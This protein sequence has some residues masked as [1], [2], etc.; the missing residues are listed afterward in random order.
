MRARP[1]TTLDASGS[2]LSD[3]DLHCQLR[4]TPGTARAGPATTTTRRTGPASGS[5]GFVAPS[6]VVLVA[7][8]VGAGLVGASG[9]RGSRPGRPPRR[10]GR[11]AAR[12]RRSRPVEAEPA[13]PPDATGAPP[14]AQAD[15][16]RPSG[17]WWWRWP[18][19][20]G[21]LAAVLAGP[22]HRVRVHRR[23][24]ALRLR[25]RGDARPRPGPG[26]P[27]GSCWAPG[28]AVLAPSGFWFVAGVASLVLA[29][30]AAFLPRR[31]LVGA[32]VGLLAVPALMRAEPFGFTGASALC[33]WLAVL[34]VLVSGY[35]VASRRSRER[36]RTVAT[37]AVLVALIG[38]I[39]FALAVWISFH[40][41]SSGSKSAQSGLAA[42]RQGTGHRGGRAAGQ[43]AR[44]RWARPT[45]CS[46]AGGRSP[47]HLVPFVSQQ[48][49][50]LST[51]SGQGH[52]VAAAG[53][54]VASKADYHELRYVQGQIDV[55]RLRQ[56]DGPLRTREPGAGPRRRR[57]VRGALALVGGP[58]AAARSTPSPARSTRPCPRPRW[59]SR[60]WRWPRPCSAA[61]APA[62]TSWPS[63]PRPSRAGSTASWATGPS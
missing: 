27:P 3:W 41:L 37:A 46:A 52:D 53:A 24:G 7:G 44:T 47:A 14:A 61:T 51:A 40:D 42:L 38:I 60:R 56:L 33:V 35:R 29:V 30:V 58:G 19:L 2:A 5:V 54:V 34:P 28:A 1:G 63:P 48:L 12:R 9:R 25:L 57:A 31:R 59:P 16:A 49:E 6:I 20:S 8:P 39:V 13:E 45:T 18:S 15:H 62:T 36:M 50:A 17:A 10:A 26:A 22:A 11:A 21:V 32:V 43:R 4:G 55:N 23:A